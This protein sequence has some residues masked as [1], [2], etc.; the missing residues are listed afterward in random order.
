MMKRKEK[1]LSL[2]YLGQDKRLN[3]NCITTKG[4]LKVF[5]SVN[6]NQCISNCQERYALADRI[7]NVTVNNVPPSI[8]ICIMHL[9]I[10]MQMH[11]ISIKR[12]K[13]RKSKILLYLLLFFHC[14]ISRL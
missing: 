1:K 10:T 14:L 5:L 2:N 8:S 6:L 12:K 4:G 7:D 9:Q 13:K 11:F 3:N